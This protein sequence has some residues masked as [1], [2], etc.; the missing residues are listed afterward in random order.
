MSVQLSRADWWQEVTDPDH[1]IP[2]GCPVRWEQGDE[3]FERWVHGIDWRRSGF[4]RDAAVFIDSRWQPLKTTYEVGDVIKS[5]VAENVPAD[6]V[7]LVD[8]TGCA[9]QIARGSAWFTGTS[10]GMVWE[11]ITEGI[12]LRVIHVPSGDKK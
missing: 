4:D 1:V 5:C 10:V 11:K 9:I 12:P 8:S 3:V 7:V 2:A 6:G